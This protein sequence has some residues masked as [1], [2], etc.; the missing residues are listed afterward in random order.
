M[1][2]LSYLVNLVQSC[3]VCQSHSDVLQESVLQGLSTRHASVAV[4]HAEEKC[5]LTSQLCLTPPVLNGGVCLKLKFHYM[6]YEKTASYVALKVMSRPISI[7]K[8][9]YSLPE[10]ATFLNGDCRQ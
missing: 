3:R 4:K 10:K 8:L 7:Y 6:Q 1:S 9:F 2:V 5:V